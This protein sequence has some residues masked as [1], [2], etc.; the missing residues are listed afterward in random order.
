MSYPKSEQKTNLAE[1]LTLP[2]LP[3]SVS[4]TMI[5]EHIRIEIY[6]ASLTRKY[7]ASIR[8]GVVK[9]K[10]NH[11][12]EEKMH[13]KAKMTSQRAENLVHVQQ[14]QGKHFYKKIFF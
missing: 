2:T 4:I 5:S 9:K 10:V 12:R 7:R 1:P 11:K 13:S 14:H 8:Y 3:C 6:D